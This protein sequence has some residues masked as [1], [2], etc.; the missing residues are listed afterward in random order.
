MSTIQKPSELPNSKILDVLISKS[1]LKDDYE[2]DYIHQLN[3]IRNRVSIEVSRINLLFPEY[4]PHD[5][6]YHLKRLFY[7]GDMLLGDDLIDSMNVTELFLL[8]VC[9]YAHDWGMAVSEDEKRSI[10]SGTSLNENVAKNLLDDENRRF[11]EFCQNKNIHSVD[12]GISDWQEYIRQTHAFRSGKRIRSYFEPIS[13]GVAEFAAR[14]CEGHYLDFDVIDDYTSYPT[15]CSI[16]R[17]IV[18]VKALTIYLRLIDLLDL[19]EDRTPFILWKFV[20]P[21]NKYSQMEWSKHRALQTVTF[22]NYQFTRYIQVEGSTDDHFVY[23]SIMD[24][25]RYIDDQFRHCIDI[26]NRIN[27]NYHK[28][29]LSHIDWRIAARGFE[30][31]AIEFEFDRKRMFDILSDDIYQSNPY[32][33]IRELV[34]NSIDAIKMRIEVLEKKGLSFIPQIKISVTEEENVFKVEVSDNGIG[35]DQ[36]IIRNYLAVAGRSY[37]KS[38]DFLK[39][40]LKLD[41]I[42]RFGIGV[43]SCFMVADFVEIKTFKDPNT[44]HTQEYLKI[45]IPSKEN[46]FKI[47]KNKELLEIGTSFK[48]IVVKEKLPKE[49]NG[50]TIKFNVTEYLS[51]V[52]G[53]VEFPIVIS[54]HGQ[55]NKIVAPNYS[56][57]VSSFTSYKINYNFPIET[58][59]FPQSVE[60]VKKYFNQKIIR[61]KEDLH[62]ENFDGCITYLMPVSDDIDILNAGH[63]WPPNDV[64]IVD[65]KN[66]LSK[67]VRIR[68]NSEW[69]RY[70]RGEFNKIYN[71][72]ILDKSYRVFM[73]G[74]LLTNIVPPEITSIKNMASESFSRW[75]SGGLEDSFII[76]QLVAN[77]PKPTEVKLDLARTTIH[78][79][80]RWDKPIWTALFEYLKRTVIRDILEQNL[81]K[82]LLSLGRLITFYKLN[83]GIIFESLI[84]EQDF[85]VPSI[86]KETGLKFRLLNFELDDEIRIV[87]RNFSYEIAKLIQSTYIPRERYEGGAL[88]LW[89]GL[90]STLI[91]EN[92]HDDLIPASILNL[93]ELV[94]SFISVR[95][96]FSGISFVSSPLGGRFYLVQ[97]IFSKH[98]LSSNLKKE[99]L[100]QLINGN[101][102][103]SNQILHLRSLVEYEFYNLPKIVNFPEPFTESFAFGFNYL[104]FSHRTTQML[105]KVC[106]L[107]IIAKNN[108]TLTKNIT[109]KMIDIINNLPFLGYDKESDFNLPDLNTRINEAFVEAYDNGLLKGEE[110]L[111]HT[112]DFES[113][114]PNSIQYSNEAQ[115]TVQNIPL[116]RYLTGNNPWG[117]SI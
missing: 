109:G 12:I 115:H 1:N 99:Q 113:F 54:E 107:L 4:T 11:H 55:V 9:L 66:D 45:T 100:L 106:I 117:I 14:I 81:E 47:E 16:H 71:Y 52:A 88:T 87:P 43:L 61:L 85:P 77:I 13:P 69:T 73:D 94:K 60:N 97:E 17:D 42:S 92:P 75:R 78:S 24:L 34:Q 18:N 86:E 57:D 83:N 46:Y 35:M 59:V 80:E 95:Y 10:I 93:N 110:A 23:M 82:R 15:D 116:K 39:V 89:N 30:P 79:Q 40:G 103:E 53:F 104:N 58:A 105:V 98:S 3:D 22:P 41:P 31:I 72:A 29:N 33:F 49:K 114:V 108:G 65:Y 62:L 91:F 48:V 102:Y 111:Y 32:V 7:V 112:I 26:L 25:K 8:S 5:E 64:L 6:K 44:T 63:S 20:A 2:F 50:L 67:E 21:R 56:G 68:W 19:G 74:I 84:K 27:T 101:N 28:L 37:Y 96:F 38:T 90:E 70:S 36:Y 76:P 51:K